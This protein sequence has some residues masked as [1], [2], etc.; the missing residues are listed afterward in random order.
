VINKVVEEALSEA[1]FIHIS[2]ELEDTLL[3]NSLIVDD[4]DLWCVES[5]VLVESR[6]R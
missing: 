6:F 3:R 1:L 4:I 5:G 2:R